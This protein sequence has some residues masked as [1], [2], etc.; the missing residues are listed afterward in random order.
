M[1]L[2]EGGIRGFRSR[3]LSFSAIGLG[4]TLTSILISSFFLGVLKTP[5]YLTYVVMYL[6][7]I[8][9]SYILNVKYTF[10]TKK[11]IKS[12][13]LFYINYGISF[14]IGYILLKIFRNNLI[15]DNVIIRILPIPIQFAWN[16]L[17]SHLILKKVLIN[18]N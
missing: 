15:W 6:L 2:L 17:F 4:I 16:F 8:E 11:D 3:F 5:L 1:K 12:N 7:T 9:V 14:I 18:I 13:V 10:K